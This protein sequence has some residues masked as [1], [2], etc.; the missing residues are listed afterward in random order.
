[1]M[2][3]I[4]QAQ[5]AR[6]V[7]VLK[8]G[9]MPARTF[10]EK[11][12]P[13]RHEESG[14]AK[15]AGNT[16]LHRLG[17]LGYVEKAGDLWFLRSFSNTVPMGLGAGLGTESGGGL[18]TQLPVG[19]PA[20]FPA[21]LP[22]SSPTTLPA[23]SP[24]SSPGGFPGDQSERSR[25]GQLIALADGSVAGVT[26][27]IALGNVR[28]RGVLVDACI[29]EACAFAVLRGG[30]LNVY[31]PVGEMI[32]NLSPAEGARALFLRWKQ[33]GLAPELP[34][35]GGSAWLTADDGMIAARGAWKPAGAGPQW[36]VLEEPLA[37]RIA[38]QRAAAGLGLP[39][40]R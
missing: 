23:V 17:K 35:R 7:D 31:P 1:V 3:E 13:G 15:I 4:T 10:A 24:T 40:V 2:Y 29:A 6:S 28:I 37:D 21:Q 5:I 19:L 20:G 36:Q 30:S 34:H 38:R 18:G 16:V 11:M 26:H 27:D 9:P 8:N 39:V 14:R 25:L 12:W 33:S 32:V 22:T